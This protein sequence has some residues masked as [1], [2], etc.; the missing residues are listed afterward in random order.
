MVCRN[1]NRNLPE[2]TSY[3]HYCGAHQIE[4]LPPTVPVGMPKPDPISVNPYAEVS[5]LAYGETVPANDLPPVIPE[6]VPVFGGQPP[7]APVTFPEVG[8]LPVNPVSPPPPGGAA[9][10]LDKLGKFALPLAA[11]LLVVAIV[12][13]VSNAG[14]KKKLEK[15]ESAS[16]GIQEE[17]EEALEELEETISQQNQTLAEQQDKMEALQSDANAYT[18]MVKAMTEHEIAFGSHTFQASERFVVAKKGYTGTKITLTAHWNKEENGTVYVEHSSD[19]AEVSFDKDSWTKNVTMTVL[20]KEVGFT[21]ATFS[22]SV[23]DTTFS[24]LI[25]VVE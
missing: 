3:C 23:D 10:I 4:D 1:C 9:G 15:A 20:P 5:P 18:A 22:N 17:Y 11:I 24:V 13:G 7:V 14:L 16:A 25:L 19:C 6:T 12:L 2:G 21:V 8:N